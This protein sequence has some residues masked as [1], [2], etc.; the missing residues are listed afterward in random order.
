MNT[1]DELRAL[2]EEVLEAYEA[3][4]HSVNEEF[5]PTPESDW[6]EELIKRMESKA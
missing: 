4:Q 5:D 2:F 3:A 1:L 6:K